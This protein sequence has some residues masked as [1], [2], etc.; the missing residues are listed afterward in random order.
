MLNAVLPTP[1]QM[2]SQEGFVS[3]SSVF[4]RDADFV[5]QKDAFCRSLQIVTGISLT[6]GE[7]GIV[8]QKDLSIPADAYVLEASDQ[9][10]IL[11]ASD[12]HGISFA[13]ATALQCIEVDENG[14]KCPKVRIEDR[15]DKEYRALMIDLSS[16]WHPMRTVL[17]YVDV[18]YVLK[19]KYLHLHFID[20]D[21]YT[22]PSKAF[23]LIGGGKEQYTEE[24]IAQLNQYAL[25]RGIV[26]IPEFETPGHAASMTRIYPE[27]FANRIEGNVGGL[28]TEVGMLMAE[29]VICPG[30]KEC[31]EGIRTLLG[32]ICDL[33]PYSPYIHIGGDEAAY[34][35]WDSC[36]DCIAYR[37]K[38]GIADSHELYSEIVGRVANMVLDLGR[39]P[40]VWEGF[41]EKGVDYI[42][43]ETIVIAWESHYMLAGEILKH[44]FKI[45]NGAWQPLYIVDSA[46]HRWRPQEI[47]DW[48]V[49]EWQHWWPKSHA[50]LNPIHI[51]A[52]DD[53]LGA[54]ISSWGCTY[55]QDISRVVEN[56]CALTERTWNVERLL[57]FG[58]YASK[59]KEAAKVVHYLIQDR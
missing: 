38:H 11:S 49:Y 3:L 55:E 52:T 36:P 5:G 48:N 30:R 58:E 24:E 9:G 44:G 32:E 53:L 28:E 1:K 39:T 57:T 51:P 20:M 7:G 35:V 25:D 34:S 31:E 59:Q 27:I 12:V 15:P 16:R 21:R 22:L 29:S 4:C 14:L 10:L 46:T 45:I 40:I 42:P 2:T 37:E 6:E 26:I 41:P 50:T 8:F 43:K 17:K 33:F 13:A 47:M 54:Q 56:L 18:C 19:I 23:P